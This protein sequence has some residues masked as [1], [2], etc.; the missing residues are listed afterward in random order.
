M[1]RV[2]GLKKAGMIGTLTLGLLAAGL[3]EP[4]VGRAASAYDLYAKENVRAEMVRLHNTPRSGP[5]VLLEHPDWSRKAADPESADC[6]DRLAVYLQGLAEQKQVLFGHQSDT[7]FQVFEGTEST[8]KEL[9]G[10]ISGILGLDTLTLTGRELDITDPKQ[11]MAKALEITM[12]AAE[13]GAIITLSCHMPNFGSSGIRKQNGKWYFGDCRLADA[14]DLSGN[15]G[16]RILP[17]RVYHSRFCAYLDMIAEYGLALQEENIPVLFRPFHEGNGDWFWWGTAISDADYQALFRYTADYLRGK[18]VHNFLYVYS[19][20]GPVADEKEYL[21]RYPGDAYVDVMAFDQYDSNIAYPLVY[22]EEFMKSLETSC[23]TV[24]AAA[25]GHGKI[26]AV[27]ETGIW[28]QKPDGSDHEGLLPSG[29]PMAGKDWYGQ[30]GRMAQEYG[31][32]YYLVWVSTSVRET[33][34]PYR[35]DLYRGHEMADEFLDFYNQPY[36]I[37]AHET[38]FY[39]GA[40][41]PDRD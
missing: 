32:P 31:I 11:A 19:V 15:A 20:N 5:G 8:V 1:K 16:R 35:Y 12:D 10:D 7:Y 39:G 30:L 18:G 27:S 37:F 34:V 36:S 6:A 24:S 17:G 28:V 25:D 22:K 2:I 40:F 4:T 3:G 23:R 29:N 21:A 9:T 14:K 38:N 41:A 13:Q 33:H 26:P